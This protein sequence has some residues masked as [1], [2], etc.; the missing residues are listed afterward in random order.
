LEASALTRT[1]L[2]PRSR[3]LLAA[4]SDNRL[5]VVAKDGNEAAFVVIYD[6][7]HR[8]LLGFCRHMLGSREDAED[9]LQ[10][11]FASAFRALPRGEPVQLKPWLYTIARNRCLSMLRAR[12][13]HPVE[14]VESSSSTAGLSEEVERRAE[15]RELLSDIEDLPERQRAALVLTE[16]GALGHPE[17]AKVLDCET[18]QVKSFVFQARSALIEDRRAREVPCAE[19]REQLATAT[20]GELRRRSLRRHVRQCQ[21][22]AE[23]RDDIR[24]QR[25]MLALALPV[26][27]SLGLKESTL[28]AAGIGGGGAAG[29]G[30]LIAALGA[31]SAAKVVAVGVAAGGALGGVAATDPSLVDK[32]Q[33]AVDRATH[34]AVSAVFG[35]SLDQRGSEVSGTKVEGSFDRDAARDAA[36][37]KTRRDEKA[38]RGVSSGDKRSPGVG[39]R[40]SRG[41]GPP[42]EGN[43]GKGHAYGR[44]GG[45]PPG[46]NGRG[47]DKRANRGAKPRGPSR[48]GG[49]NAER[50]AGTDRVPGGAGVGGG[51][52]PRS[53]PGGNGH[54]RAPPKAARP[55][56]PKQESAREPRVR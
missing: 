40:K 11:S 25:G 20:A 43:P 49:G 33:A 53:L 36:R 35:S 5:A 30:G 27:P 55:A 34:G 29:G 6:R 14:E 23:F 2:L 39:R 24:R 18:R 1:R 13:E 44:D 41:G 45:A 8:G 52:L 12:R 42:G 46:S 15:L 31:S 26:I 9:A 47:R 16:V 22:C 32:A 54:D 38:G 56:G 10:Q 19:I 50:A 37:Q 4:L 51:W 21:G 3:R 28:A 7:H 48:G 17:V